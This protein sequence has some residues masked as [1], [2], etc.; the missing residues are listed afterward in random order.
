MD[1]YLERDANLHDAYKGESNGE[2]LAAIGGR[3]DVSVAHGGEGD[4]RVAGRKSVMRQR[5]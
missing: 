1:T 4:L 5:M 3:A 2:K